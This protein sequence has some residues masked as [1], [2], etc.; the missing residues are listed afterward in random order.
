[1]FA[2]YQEIAQLTLSLQEHP[3]RPVD[4]L[5]LSVEGDQLFVVRDEPVGLLEITVDRASC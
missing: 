3:Y 5:E 1:V 2:S 4:L